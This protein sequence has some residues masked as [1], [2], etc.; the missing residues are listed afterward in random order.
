MGFLYR[1]LVRSIVSIGELSSSSPVERGLVQGSIVN[2]G[3]G[4]RE[5]GEV[6]IWAAPLPQQVVLLFRA[7]KE[8]SALKG[9]SCSPAPS[10]EPRNSLNQWPVFLTLNGVLGG[11]PKSEYLIQGPC[12]EWMDFRASMN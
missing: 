6:Q 11:S 8:P 5:W 9:L 7:T 1:K 10:L 12:F 2:C 3:Q 4:I